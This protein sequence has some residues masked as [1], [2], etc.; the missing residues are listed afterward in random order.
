MM[1]AELQHLLAESPVVPVVTIQDPASAVP[2]AQALIDGGVPVI[3]ITLRTAAAFDAIRAIKSEIP[4]AIVGAGTVLNSRDIDRAIEAGSEFI[5]TPGTTSSLLKSAVS[6]GLPF[7]P[8]VSTVSDLMCCL[9]QGLNTLK[10]FPAEA[11]GGTAVLKAFAGPFPDVRFCPTGG[12]GLHNLAEYF[13]IPSVIS[14]GGTWI[15]PTR[16]IESG[17]WKGITRLAME[18]R[19]KIATVLE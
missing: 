5:V 19:Q 8:G 11:A 12:I 7:M 17:D 3:E 10:F 18:A 13:A 2:L 1:N 4:Q 6:C 9:E 16:L 14:V 15:A